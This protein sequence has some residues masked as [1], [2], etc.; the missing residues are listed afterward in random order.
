M[1]EDELA[2]LASHEALD[3]MLAAVDLRGGPDGGG[4]TAVPYLSCDT[5]AALTAPHAEATAVRLAASAGGRLTTALFG[6]GQ[7]AAAAAAT[8]SGGAQEGLGLEGAV[9]GGGGGAAVGGQQPALAAGGAGATDAME[10]DVGGAGA[11][12][13]GAAGIAGAPPEPSTAAD[14]G[15]AA[16]APGAASADTAMGEAGAQLADG[17]Q[18]AALPAAEGGAAPAE[19]QPAAAAA[20]PG[21]AEMAEAAPPQAADHASQQQQQQELQHQP[22]DNTEQQTK[23]EAQAVLGCS[24]PVVP[25]A[26]LAAAGAARGWAYPSDP[27]LA[28]HGVRAA[29]EALREVAAVCPPLATMAGSRAIDAVRQN[30]GEG[31]EGGP[32]TGC[33]WG[34]ERAHGRSGRCSE[35]CGSRVT[36]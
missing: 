7:R 34:C 3:A 27:H 28:R 33:A 20:A 5:L 9:Q 19:A 16:A 22:Q 12:A 1:S 17:A 4:G 35:C 8:A 10:V 15:Q 18:A 2:A 24:G 25:G 32:G 21:D 29:L 30:A 14:A 26:L 11:A 31:R 13:G 36:S 6:E 23:Q